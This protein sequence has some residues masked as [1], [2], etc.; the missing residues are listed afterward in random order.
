[1]GHDSEQ[2]QLAQISG[3]A[4]HIWPCDDVECLAKF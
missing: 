4:T 1:M 2:A 3:L